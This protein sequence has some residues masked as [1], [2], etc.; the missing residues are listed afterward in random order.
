MNF[1][2]PTPVCAIGSDIRVEIAVQKVNDV[3]ARQ[4]VPGILVKS[5]RSQI[6]MAGDRVPASPPGGRRPRMSSRACAPRHRSR[7]SFPPPVVNGFAD[8]RI[9]GKSLNARHCA[10]WK[11]SGPVGSQ[12]SD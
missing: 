4:F 5:R 9:I 1:I 8:Q 12:R 10:S 3:I 6:M 11:T 2:F 7:A